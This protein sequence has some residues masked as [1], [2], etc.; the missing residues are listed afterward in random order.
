MKVFKYLSEILGRFACKL[1]MDPR[2]FLINAQVSC[3]LDLF[4]NLTSGNAKSKI[5]ALGYL[6]NIP[7]NIWETKK[8]LTACLCTLM[9]KFPLSLY[10]GKNEQKVMIEKIYNQVFEEIEKMN[11]AKSDITLLRKIVRIETEDKTELID[12]WMGKKEFKSLQIIVLEIIKKEDNC[13]K[14][15]KRKG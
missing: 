1:Q 13:I 2:N 15:L 7:K 4:G 3:I 5:L 10:K 12:N 14:T 9:D 11:I 8:G 6:S